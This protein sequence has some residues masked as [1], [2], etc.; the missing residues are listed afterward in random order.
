MTCTLSKIAHIQRAAGAMHT[1]SDAN[2][3]QL[4]LST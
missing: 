2:E 3:G 1:Q 4:A